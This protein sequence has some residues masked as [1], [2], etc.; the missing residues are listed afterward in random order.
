[1]IPRSG[2][3]CIRARLTDSARFGK[4]AGQPVFQVSVAVAGGALQLPIAALLCLLEEA[5][6]DW[7]ER[8]TS[9]AD[10]LFGKSHIEGTCISVEF[11]LGLPAWGWSARMVV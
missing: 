7:R 3:D 2:Q 6:I 9:D 4:P 11:I 10:T 1:M 5:G 8:I